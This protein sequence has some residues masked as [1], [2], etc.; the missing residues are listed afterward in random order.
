[1]NRT[2]LGIMALIFGLLIVGLFFT[3]SS[4]NL[5]LVRQ[6]DNAEGSTLDITSN[7]GTLIA[8]VTMV[9]VGSVVGMGGT[10]YGL[11]WFL[12]R[13]VT[14]VQQQP[15]QGFPLLTPGEQGEAIGSFIENNFKLILI[16]MIVAAPVAF[17][18]L[19]LLFG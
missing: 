15:D 19:I 6:V 16:G 8:I 5:T 4:S 11:M 7:Q 3:T 14:I 10:I 9:V 12:N 2:A 13:E 17:V 1:M 18:I